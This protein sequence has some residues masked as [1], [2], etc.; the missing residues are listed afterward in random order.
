MTRG[1]RLA[2]ASDE[3]LVEGAAVF[4]SVAAAEAEVAEVADEEEEE[5][6]EVGEKREAGSM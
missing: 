2:L 4:G 1:L 3:R 5:K 6:A